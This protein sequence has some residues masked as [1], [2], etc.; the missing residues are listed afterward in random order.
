[1]KIAE[2]LTPMSDH[3]LRLAAQVGVEE[4]VVR[5]PGDDADALD[6]VCD[7][8]E[9]FGMRVGVVEGFLPLE[10]IKLG[11]SGREEEL[12]AMIRL[13]QRM[14]QRGVGVLCYNFMPTSDWSRT[15]TD[16]VE[17]G[18][19]LVSGFDLTQVATAPEAESAIVTAEELWTHLSWFLERILPVAEQAGVDLAMHPDDPPLSPLMGCERIMINVPAFER[20]L[21]LSPS[22]NNGI[23]FCQ[24]NFLAMGADL[25]DAVHSL[26]SAIKYVHFRDVQ[27]SA[28]DFRETFHDNG[29][30]NM[31]AALK[32]YTDANF[33]GPL[34]CDHV[35]NRANRDTPCSADYM[36][37]VSFRGC[38]RPSNHRNPSTPHD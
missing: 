34:R 14:G 18:G 33:T 28:E 7:K 24:G 9:S 3:H 17:R 10:R 21:S 4:I 38:C 37:S 23:C 26:Q 20:L 22:P 36:R 13:I 2:V 12:A 35:R 30:T 1:M 5:Y 31:A 16:L 32:L 6:T 15:R 25:P 27:G 29:P 11:Q 8:V 19:A